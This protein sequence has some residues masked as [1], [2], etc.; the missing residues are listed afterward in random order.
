[1]TQQEFRCLVATMREYQRQF[2]AS[3]IGSP[4][5]K[6]ALLKAKREEAKVDAELSGLPDPQES[7]F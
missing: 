4:A 3:P 5:R 7:L 1:M 2:F 6:E